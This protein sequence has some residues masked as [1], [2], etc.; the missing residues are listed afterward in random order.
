MCSS[1]FA[2]LHP[3]SFLYSYDSFTCMLN[4]LKLFQKSLRLLVMLYGLLFSVL[5]IGEFL[6]SCV[7][8]HW[9]CLMWSPICC[10]VHP[11]NFSCQMLVC[12][13]FLEFPFSPP[14]SFLLLYWDFCIF[15]LI[16]S[17]FSFKSCIFTLSASMDWFFLMSHFPASTV[18][19]IIHWT[20]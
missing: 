14:E 17:N 10:W 20:W 6:L 8:A 19:F 4:Q 2:T 15:P 9:L 11:V 13:S 5:Q 18:F 1:L 12:Y 3:Q 16:L 7:Q